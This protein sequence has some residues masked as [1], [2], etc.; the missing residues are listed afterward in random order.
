MLVRLRGIGPPHPVPETGALSTELQ[1][2]LYAAKPQEKY[3]T[4]IPR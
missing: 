4:H 3:I 2:Q 1:A